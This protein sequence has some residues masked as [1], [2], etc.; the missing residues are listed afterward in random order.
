VSHHLSDWTANGLGGDKTSQRYCSFVEAI[1]YSLPVDG[2]DSI[3]T[4]G[5]YSFEAATF[6]S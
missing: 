2:N 1:Y 5:D 3:G 4:G 6:V